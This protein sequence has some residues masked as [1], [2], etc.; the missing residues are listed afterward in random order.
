M[1]KAEVTGLWK[2]WETDIQSIKD[3]TQ[4]SGWEISIQELK[5]SMRA[6]QFFLLNYLLIN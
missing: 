6:N 5:N 4:S 2:K 1:Q 3:G